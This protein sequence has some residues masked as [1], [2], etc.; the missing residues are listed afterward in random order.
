MTAKPTRR[1]RLQ[2]IFTFLVFFGGM[3]FVVSPD[4]NRAQTI[5]RISLV[6]VGLIGLI[7]VNRPRR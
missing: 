6:V 7:W 3:M 4:P 5:F 2:V 1:E